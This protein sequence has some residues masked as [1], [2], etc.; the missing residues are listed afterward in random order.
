MEVARAFIV[1]PFGTQDGIDF[2]RVEN[3]LIAPALKLAGIEGRTTLE[4][5]RQGNIR[6]DMFRLLVLSDLVIADVSIHNANVFYELGIRHGLRDRHTLL[7]RA[8][9]TQDKYPFDLQTDRYGQYDPAD[10]AATLPGFLESLKSTLAD[11]NKDSP[12]FQLLPRLTPHDRGALMVVPFDFQEEVGI[13]QKARRAGDLRLVAEEV[14]GFEWG[15]AGLRIVGDAQ[16]QIKAF[17]GAKETF[18]SLRGLDNSDFQANYRLGTIYQKLAATALGPDAKLDC[19]TRSEQAINRV[20]ARTMPPNDRDESPKESAERRF[21]R[22][23]GHSLLGSNAKTRWIDD[24]QAAAAPD[25]QRDAALRSPNLASSIQHYL[26]GFAE[27]LDS[28]YAGINALAMLTIQINLAKALPDIWAESFDDGDAA[29][30]DLKTRE[31]RA[32][33]LAAT[34]Q[35]AVGNDDKVTRDGERFDIW[36][37]ISRADLSFLTADRPPQ[38]G[39]AYR[40]VLANANPFEIDAARRNLLLF[41]E[42]GVLSANVEA[43]LKEMNQAAPDKPAALPVRVILFTGHMLDAPGRDKDKARFPNTPEAVAAA[44]KMIEKVVKEEMNEDGGVA[45]GIAGGAC[46]SDILFHEVCNAL[47]IPT[48]LLLALPE[49]QFQ[50]ESVNRGGVDWVMRYQQL[51][52]RVTP[53]VL[54]DSKDLPRWLSGRR[55]YDIWQRNNLWMMFNALATQAR[56]LT[57]I[58]LYNREKDPDGPGGTAHLVNVAANWGFKTVE[59]DARQLLKAGGS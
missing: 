56:N 57:L 33:R 54:A 47:N 11:T 1:R 36:K 38:V 24:W 27:D 58:A 14:R 20:L 28:F 8:K 52:Q 35:L 32:G 37:E 45:F 17:A 51:C 16:F 53:R 29:V 7:M 49:A 22:A 30:A 21:H 13:A 59:L 42:L 9:G 23:E 39:T 48:Q 15:S 6:E 4:I 5:T 46:G 2:D 18:E 25:A 26:D 10:P 3:D 41:R 34:L 44:R 43:A 40:K 19:I 55:G 50:A 31:R 12:V